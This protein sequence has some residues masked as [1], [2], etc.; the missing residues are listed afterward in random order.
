M[1]EPRQSARVEPLTSHEI[2]QAPERSNASGACGQLGRGSSPM[3]ASLEPPTLAPPGAGLPAVQ[4]LF[5]RFILAV[6]SAVDSRDSA[7][8]RFNAEACR[9]RKMVDPL[10]E[11]VGVRR[12]LVPRLLGL[13]DSSRFWSP[14]M[15]VEHLVIVDTNMFRIMTDL[16]AGRLHPDEA[17]IEDFK[18]A[19]SVGRA[20]LVTFDKLVT[21]FNGQV[22]QWPDLRTRLPPRSPVVRPARRPSLVVPC[23]IAPRDSPATVETHPRGRSPCACR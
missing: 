10:D 14:Y 4:L 13:E 8:R 7:L 21:Q 2:P 1:T 6:A 23:R 22:P 19:P 17:R 16:V 12:V 20:S 3:S 15:V 11:T 18:P 5:S 9:I